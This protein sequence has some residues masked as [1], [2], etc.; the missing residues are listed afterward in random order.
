[1]VETKS[2]ATAGE[3]PAADAHNDSTRIWHAPGHL[4]RYRERVAAAR[5]RPTATPPNSAR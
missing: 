2:S 5:S 4:A 1:M 3:G